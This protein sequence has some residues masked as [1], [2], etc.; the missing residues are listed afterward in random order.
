MPGVRAAL[1]AGRRQAARQALA[2]AL[3]TDPRAAWAHVA[4]ANIAWADDRESAILHLRR[5]LELDPQHVDATVALAQGLSHRALLEGPHLQEAV[6]L[7]LGVLPR[8][9]PSARTLA[10]GIL[11]RG[12]QYEQAE[13]LGGLSELGRYAAEH[14]QPANLLLQ[15]AKVQTD[16]DRLEVLHQHR[17]WAG[18]LERRAA[19]RPIVR[20]RSRAPGSK[21]RLG[22]LSPDLRHHV[23][24]FFAQPLFQHLDERFELFCYAPFPRAPDYV[25][26][27]IASRVTAFRQLPPDDRAAAEVVA[28]DELDILLDLSGPLGSRP[29]ILAYKPAPRQA[30]WL[31]YPHSLGLAAMDYFV[32]DPYLV[33]PRKDLLV[34]EPLLMPESWICMT[35]AAFHPEPR[36]EQTTPVER[37][38]HVTFGTANDA[39]KYNPRLL[40][41]WA[42]V[43]AAV[44][45]SRFM[46]V[47]PEAGA[48]G[49]RD[50][51][52]RHFAAE[53]VAVDRLDFH[54]VS[55]R[56]KVRELYGQ[57][58]IALDTF[59][60][61]GGT[62][63][64]EA[65]W[66]GVPTVSLVGEA[67]FERLS[68]SILSN[69]GLPELAAATVEDYV[70]I[71]VELAGSPARIAELRNT[72]RERILARPLGQPER[73][74]RDFY[75]LMASAIAARP[76]KDR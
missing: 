22:F 36:V 8:L 49:F 14:D 56:A 1:S 12:A 20:P 48:P 5:A 71:A 27:R 9:P 19:D 17:L 59:P 54:A 35:P 61:T 66:M 21:H 76:E 52:A 39:Y 31:G 74:A 75:D 51:V 53:G 29:G 18:S 42:R 2:H 45:G 70:R 33:P 63:T 25:Q 58:D 6:E 65:L 44:P 7:I 3:R 60:L 34:E 64:C 67:V 57:M 23:V 73:F 4:L 38:G 68:G 69:A 37:T 30:S 16:E 15:M 13:A 55:G 46:I 24:A 11:W 10:A 72:A 28:A 41:T 47:R 32:A 50:S 26:E 40:R 62:T 43:L